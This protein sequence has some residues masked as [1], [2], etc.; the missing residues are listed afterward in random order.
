M[1]ALPGTSLAYG[2]A[3]QSH[4]SPKA[5]LSFDITNDRALRASI[6]HAYR[7][8]T[9]GELF[10]EQINGISIINNN[11]NL[12]PEDDLSKELTAE[13]AHGNGSYRFTLFQDDV[14]N[15]IFNQTNTTVIPNVTNFQNIDKVRSRGA[16]VAYEGQDVSL[17]GL[18][19]I[20]NVAYTQSKI[21]ANANNPASVGK[22]FYRIP[23]VARQSGDDL[24]RDRKARGHRGDALLETPVQ[25]AHQYGHQSE[26]VRRHEHVFRR[27][28]EL[29][30]KPPRRTELGVGID[31]RYYIHPYAGRTFYVEGRIG[32]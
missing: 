28:Y 29:T 13:W 18:D 17:R 16:E 3:S 2:D 1:C 23:L 31:R 19:L 30:Y 11:P 32:I 15:T 22:Y 7:F 12:K 8:P 5:S 10:Q 21:I 20:A 25:H 24:S 9:V 26:H 6:G 14:K 4:W 27:R